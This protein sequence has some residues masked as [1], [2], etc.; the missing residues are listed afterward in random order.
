MVNLADFLKQIKAIASESPTYRLGGDGSDGTCDCIGLIIGAIRRAGG[1]W[2]GTHGS[3]YAA[4][5]EMS[6]LHKQLTADQL[7]LGW[8]VY[9][10]RGPQDSGYNLPSRYD[11]HPD[12]MDYYHVGVVTSVEPLEITHCTSGGGADGIVVD[13]KQGKWLYGG[14]LAKISYDGKEAD[15]VI[16]AIVTAASGTSVNMRKAPGGALL[17]RVPVGSTV[18][19]QERGAEWCKIYWN[20]KTGYMMSQY[21]TFNGGDS[22]GT[23]GGADD[24]ILLSLPQSVASALM[25]S[26]RNAGVA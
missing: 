10:A 5:N 4:R 15:P 16:T 14:P 6:S 3:N 11:G 8:A 2:S 18:N 25:E 20:G 24:H 12:R 7:E 22:G 21:L 17:D 9:K 13:T 1:K 19:V 23:P 26:L